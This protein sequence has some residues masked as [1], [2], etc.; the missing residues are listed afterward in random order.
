MSQHYFVQ[1]YFVPGT[2]NRSVNKAAQRIK[3]PHK[4][5]PNDRMELHWKFKR[6]VPQ[7][8][9][10]TFNYCSWGGSSRGIREYVQQ[11]FKEFEK[12]HQSAAMYV[13]HR[14]G[15]DPRFVVSYLN[16]Q[17][18]IIPVPNM[19]IIDINDWLKRLFDMSGRDWRGER[20]KKPWHTENPSMQGTWNPFLFK[21]AQ[22]LNIQY[23]ELEDE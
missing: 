18:R 15:Y 9:R 1:K 3:V 6:Y 8:K 5:P 12:K 21:P 16:G 22:D 14:G 10:I 7:V 2:F 19:D 17:D 20:L 23:D 4:K 11:H 13:Q